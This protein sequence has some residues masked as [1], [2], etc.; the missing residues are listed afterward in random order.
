MRGRTKTEV[1]DKLRDL[2]D[3]IAVGVKTPA[4]Y[5]VQQA[6]EDWLGSGLDGRSAATVTKYRHVLK[7]VLELIGRPPLRELTAHDVRQALTAVGR[8][9]STATVAIA[10]NAL[11]RAIRH[12]EARD[13]DRRNVAA[14]TDTPKGQQ[15]RPSKALE[16]C[17]CTATAGVGRTSSSRA[18]S[19]RPGSTFAWAGGFAEGVCNIQ[20]PAASICIET[21]RGGAGLMAAGIG[22][23]GR[24][25]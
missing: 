11:T 10:H 5:S 23:D 6:V 9:Q 24:G 4:A 17:C 13:L 20:V 7:P 18:G 25:G 12:A 8:D 3:V 16:S 14:L 19:G 15:G 1:R 22:W 2:R 21:A